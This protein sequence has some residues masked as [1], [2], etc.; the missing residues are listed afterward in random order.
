MMIQYR[1]I[2]NNYQLFCHK[3][4]KG[5][6]NERK[7]LLFNCILI[8]ITPNLNVSKDIYNDRS[9]ILRACLNTNLLSKKL[10]IDGK[11]FF[12]SKKD[13]L[14][15]WSNGSIGFKKTDL[16]NIN[17]DELNKIE[18]DLNN[19]NI[20]VD[21]NKLNKQREK[22]ERRKLKKYIIKKLLK[23]STQKL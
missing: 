18:N 5:T 23:N 9:A 12:E 1:L 11:N 16:S 14:M 6:K 13:E 20:I 10:M 8:L 21:F 3:Y 4:T 7:G 2:R 15:N 22:K 19:N 17:Y